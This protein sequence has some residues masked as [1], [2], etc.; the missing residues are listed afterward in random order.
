MAQGGLGPRGIEHHSMAIR[1]QHLLSGA[2]EEA[3]SAT[4]ALGLRHAL[5]HGDVHGARVAAPDVGVGQAAGQVDRGAPGPA[6]DV[7]DGLRGAGQP[8]AQELVEGRVGP[9]EG[10]GADAAVQ[11]QDVGDG[12]LAGEQAPAEAAVGVPDPPQAVVLAAVEAQVHRGLLHDEG[13]VGGLALALGLVNEA[14]AGVGQDGAHLLLAD[15]HAGHGGGHDL[16]VRL[17]PEPRHAGPRARALGLVHGEGPLDVHLLALED[18]VFVHD[19]VP[20]ERLGD[21]AN[22]ITVQP[23]AGNKDVVHSLGALHQ[24]GVSFSSFVCDR[25]RGVGPGVTHV[26]H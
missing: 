15:Q 12:V 17:L 10:P 21:L 1:A 23:P 8:R 13:L 9:H 19:A 6:P 14:E 7:H 26:R 18:A 25:R 20:H 4:D 24:P 16:L 2:C 11:L 22:A 5:G 3:H